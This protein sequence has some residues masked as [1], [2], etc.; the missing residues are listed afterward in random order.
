[1]SP[2]VVQWSLHHLLKGCPSSVERNNWAFLW[3]IS[4]PHLSLFLAL[5]FYSHI[6]RTTRSASTPSSPC[7]GPSTCLPGQVRS[8]HPE[9]PP[10]L[11]GAQTREAERNVR[12]VA[13][14]FLH[15]FSGGLLSWGHPRAPFLAARLLEKL[16]QAWAEPEGSVLICWVA[17]SCWLLRSKPGTRTARC[18]LILLCHS[19]LRDSPGEV[20]F[21]WQEVRLGLRAGCRVPGLELQITRV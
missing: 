2:V 13:C 4:P 16:S 1:M 5:V 7:P 11:P 12:S 8:R 9:L 17:L 14:P 20:A 10:R 3:H 6:Y 19:S 21:G 18:L 15:L